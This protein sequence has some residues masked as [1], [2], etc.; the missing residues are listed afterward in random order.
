[1]KKALL[2]TAIVA[3]IGVSAPEIASAAS[4][5]DLLGMTA[6]V[7]QTT[8]VLGSTLQVDV[9]GSYFAMDNDGNGSHSGGEKVAL[10]PGTD[11][12]LILDSTQ[13]IGE[14]DANWDFFSNTGNHYSKANTSISN[15]GANSF[16]VSMS[17]WTV[18]WAGGD[19]D[20][21]G[22]NANFSGD[23]GIASVTC[24]VDCSDGD[25]YTLD[26]L[27]HTP[28]DGGGTSFKG[29]FYAFHMEG[30][31]DAADVQPPEPIPVP[32]AVWLFGSGLLGLVGVARR[33][34]TS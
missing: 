21:S 6:G 4:S 1:M 27:S 26:F 11:G 33:K 34:K 22:D 13:A 17:G 12:G 3:A 10:S 2:S 7:A 29:V 8:V 31:I 32:A 18:N 28:K 25:A 19:I 24:A 9:T 30:V 15:V 23:T 20:M 16:D 14:I 5:G